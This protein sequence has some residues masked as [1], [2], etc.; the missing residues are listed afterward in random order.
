VLTTN[1]I[2]NAGADTGGASGAGA[3]AAIWEILA[4]AA[5]FGARPLD[6]WYRLR[7]EEV[8]RRDL[9]ERLAAPRALYGMPGGAAWMHGASVGEVRALV[10]LVR[11]L[12]AL[13]PDWPLVVT[14]TTTAGRGRAAAEADAVARL[15]PVDARGPVR[16]FI[17]AV[18]PRLH[19]VVETE[20]WP[21]RLAE[22]AAR[23]IPTALVSARI[24]PER[25]PRYARLRSLYGPCLR[26][27]AL[28]APA[29][30]DDRERF[31]RL[32]ADPARLGP[33][34]NLKWDAAPVPAGGGAA[35]EVRALLGI[36]A[37]IPW[38]VLG[39]VHPGE[40]AD[41]VEATMRELGGARPPA[42]SPAATD[43]GRSGAAGAWPAG[44]LVAPRHPERFG[45]EIE[46]LAR[47]AGGLW[48]SSAG[49]APAGMRVIVLDG[50][51]LLPRTYPLACGAVLGGTFVPVGGHTPLEAAAAGCPLVAGP[52]T[53]HQSDL[54][55][56]LAAARA[57]VRCATALEAGAVLA[58]WIHDTD[59]AREAG[60]AAAREVRQR[61]GI[62]AVLAQSLVEMVR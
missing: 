23:R 62:G 47:L 4:A 31:L 39:S 1:G 38:F 25:E 10:P 28:L 18:A 20:I 24:S 51:G 5:V 46:R 35:A 12:R 41:I 36:D 53:G 29:S 8:R 27:L 59:A 21:T 43:G 37:S 34:G 49:P 52:H 11:A 45:T 44:W 2:R 16:R 61:R 7:H 58:G 17:D 15:A 32:G 50:I 6:L 40:A 26:S 42:A 54:V 57:L 13:R 22:L 19:A 33:E 55:E 30:A 48:R 56:P 9:G 3:L 60:E 14:S